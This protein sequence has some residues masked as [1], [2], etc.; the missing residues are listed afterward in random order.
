MGGSS[1]RMKANRLDMLHQ[2]GMWDALFSFFE[3]LT[4]KATAYSVAHP[5]VRVLEQIVGFGLSVICLEFMYL[6]VCVSSHSLERFVQTTMQV[7]SILLTEGFFDWQL[8]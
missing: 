4:E 2:D 3:S 1:D 6:T 8:P 7:F 5:V